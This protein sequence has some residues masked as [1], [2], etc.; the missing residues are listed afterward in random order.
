MNEQVNCQ[1]S[2]LRL[3]IFEALDL[4]GCYTEVYVNTYWRL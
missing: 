2:G 3:R 4:L 1:I